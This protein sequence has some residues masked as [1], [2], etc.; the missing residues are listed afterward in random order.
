MVQ[1]PWL[2]QVRPFFCSQMG[3]KFGST[4]IMREQ[5]S[6]FTHVGFPVGCIRKIRFPKLV[7]MTFTVLNAILVHV[8][9]GLGWRL[10]TI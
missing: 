6:E 5:K 9:V 7:E 2:S 10:Q 4:R 3:Q 8:R 1:I